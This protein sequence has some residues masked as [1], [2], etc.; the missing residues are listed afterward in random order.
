MATR[1]PGCQRRRVGAIGV[2]AG[3]GADTLVGSSSFSFELPTTLAITRISTKKGCAQA[4]TVGGCA[5]VHER[6]VSQPYHEAEVCGGSEEKVIMGPFFDNRADT[7][8]K[9]PARERL[10]NIGIHHVFFFHKTVTRI[11]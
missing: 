1:C 9:V 10:V 2:S 5:R 8:C 3:R 7:I 4:V 6:I 11:L